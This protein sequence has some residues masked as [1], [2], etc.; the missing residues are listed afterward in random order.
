VRNIARLLDPRTLLLTLFR[1]RA[2]LHD[3]E[4]YPD[5]WKFRPERY[6]KD[7]NGKPS[8]PDP[9]LLGGFGFGRR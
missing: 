8:C 1:T 7:D 9:L 5:P 2:I 6:L 3:P 4:L